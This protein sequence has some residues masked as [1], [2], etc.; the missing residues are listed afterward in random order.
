MSEDALA[1]LAA[2]DAEP[3]GNQRALPDPVD[4]LAATVPDQAPAPAPA[5]DAAPAPAPAAPPVVASLAAALAA[6]APAPP[7]PLRAP[8]PP[9][10]PHVAVR[11]P[12]SGADWRSEFGGGGQGGDRKMVCVQ[13]GGLWQKFTIILCD[14]IAESEGKPLFDARSKDWGNLLVLAADNL[15]PKDM[16]I[17]PELEAAGMTT[18]LLVQRA[19]RAKK[20]AAVRAAN[21]GAAKY[22]YVAPPV[23]R[24]PEPVASSVERASPDERDVVISTPSNGA[25][26]VVAQQPVQ[27]VPTSSNPDSPFASK[28]FS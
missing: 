19:L 5:P 26:S 17:S 23:R 16:K 12:D 4:P 8:A 15:L 18:G 11:S 20:L 14:Q 28:P 6:P 13:A 25:S 3:H 27:Q 22:V 7:P 9:P 1:F 21:A 10:P 2:Y 24:E